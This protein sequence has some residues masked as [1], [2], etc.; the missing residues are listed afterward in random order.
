MLYIY[1]ALSC[2]A[3]ILLVTLYFRNRFKELRWNWNDINLNDLTFPENFIWGAATA[4]HQ[5]E[6]NCTNNWSEFERGEN[7][8]NAPNIKD[9][10]KSGIA[11]DHWNRYKEDIRLIARLGVSHY[12]FSLEWSKIE[13]Q[14][15]QFDKQALDHYS[16]LID[17]LI[18]AG[19]TPVITLHHFTHPIWF[20]TIGAFEKQE[21]IKHLVEFSKKVFDAY[22]DRVKLWCTI[23]EPGVVAV[24]GYFTGMFPP[25]KSSGKSTAEVYKNLLEAHVQMYHALKNLE[26]GESCK[27]GIVKNINQ[28]DPW[29]RYHILDW[30][31]C[32]GLDHVFNT[33]AIE[34]FKTGK[35]KFR[36]P[37]LVWLTHTNIKAKE[38]MDF[39]GLNYYSHVHI[40][41][42]IF[43]KDYSELMYMDTDKMT[44]MPYAMYPEGIYRAI[45]LVSKLNF[46]IIITENGVADHRDS[47]RKEF[48]QKY[49]YAT[50]KSIEDGYNVIG[51]FYWSLMDNF[52]W[53]FG[54]DM[55]FGLY[56]VD[57]KNQSRELRE[58]SKTFTKIIEG[59]HV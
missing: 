32:M 13:P 25:G 6:G 50:S 38:S 34:F 44:D 37:G 4:S 8:R 39:F 10:Q 54:Y 52:E 29:R 48:I 24:Q 41:F 14:Q 23:N 45:H 33:S 19:I 35:L 28:F 20:D 36:I 9:N 5:V 15:G 57:F 21:N 3:S 7:A 30:L 18:K 55:K 43:K 22:S 27:I 58:A 12:R 40:K 17:E 59:K 53:A 26:N 42:N 31:L 11:C 46:P 56:S 16:D 51:Y 49:I 47:I 2:I 1:L